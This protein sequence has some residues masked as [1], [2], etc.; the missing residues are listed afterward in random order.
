MLTK[1]Q[2]RINWILVA[3]LLV[4]SIFFLFPVI[5]RL[6]N[7]FKPDAAITADMNSIAAFIPPALNG[8]FFEN[9]VSIIT[10]TNFLRYMANTLLYAAILIVLSIVVNGLAGYALAKIKFPF[11]D[12]WLMII[13]MLLI[14]PT[15]TVITIHFLIIAKAGLLNTIVGYILPLI[16]NPFNIYLFRQ[17]FVSLPDDVYE[18]AQLDYCGPVKYFFTMVLPMSKTVVATVSVFTFLN[19]WNDY[20]WPSLVFT[21]SD[22][23][24]AQIGLNSITSNENTTMGQTLAVITLVTIPV[25]IIYSLFSKQIVE[26]VTSTGSKEG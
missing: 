18:A 5:W 12:Q 13:I 7:S 24:T 14:V 26:G 3:V 2:K 9:Y 17:V 23:L 20:L 15:E 11:R 4:L 19:V 22:L 6:A 1:K 16:V 10:D 25:I 8:N 21:S